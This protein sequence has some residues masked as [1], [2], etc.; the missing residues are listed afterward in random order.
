M[1]SQQEQQWVARLT[2]A[3][4]VIAGIHYEVVSARIDRRYSTVIGELTWG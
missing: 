1:L 4:Q 2:T 3:R